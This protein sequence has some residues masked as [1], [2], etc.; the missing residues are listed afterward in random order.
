MPESRS[1]CLLFMDALEMGVNIAMVC[2]GVSYMGEE[3]CHFGAPTYLIVAGILSLI[4]TSLRFF[5]SLHHMWAM[6]DGVISSGEQC[7]KL[8]MAGASILV[9]V[10]NLVV[11]IWGSVVIFGNYGDWTS[12][13]DTVPTFCAY[14][15]MQFAF[16]ILILKWVTLPVCVLVVCFGVI[17]MGKSVS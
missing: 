17:C 6:R 2:V 4:A 12:R 13:N 11:L 10:C 15:P 8:L 16:V 3:Y 5:T 1:C 14:T 7:C 9:M